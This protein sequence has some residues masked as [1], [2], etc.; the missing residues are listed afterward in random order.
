MM[1][2]INSVISG[3][4]RDSFFSTPPKPVMEP[5][6]MHKKYAQYHMKYTLHLQMLWTKK[7]HRHEQRSF[8]PAPT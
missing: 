3:T 5:K 2:Y 4:G 6:N 7:F 1:I 8:K